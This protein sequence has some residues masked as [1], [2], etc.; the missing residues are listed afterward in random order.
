M[1]Q[2]KE[3]LVASKLLEESYNQLSP[4]EKDYIELINSNSRVRIAKQVNLT[5]TFIKGLKSKE[6]RTLATE[7]LDVLRS[8]LAKRPFKEAVERTLALK[9]TIKSLLSEAGESSYGGMI[10]RK[11]GN[12]N[13]LKKIVLSV[14]IDEKDSPETLYITFSVPFYPLGNDY[15]SV[16]ASLVDIDQRFGRMGRNILNKTIY[17]KGRDGKVFSGEGIWDGSVRINAV[18]PGKMA[19]GSGELA[20]HVVPGVLKSVDEAAKAAIPILKDLDSLVPQ[21]FSEADKNAQKEFRKNPDSGTQARL[22]VLKR[23][24][25]QLRGD[26][27]AEISDEFGGAF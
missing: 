3:L 20:L 10:D 24:S 23:T 21:W 4:I 6:E 16:K 7:S 17:Q 1:K 13:Y 12:Y 5:E 8:D 9:Y 14:L 19:L 2:K 18:Q 27:E 11:L 15:S 25:H 26:D 22:D